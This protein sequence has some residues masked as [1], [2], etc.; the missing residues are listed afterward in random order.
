MAARQQHARD[1]TPRRQPQTLIIAAFSCAP[2]GFSANPVLS[3]N[4]IEPSRGAVTRRKTPCQC[5]AMRTRRRYRVRGGKS[6]GP[7]TVANLERSRRAR[8]K[9]GACSRD[10]RDLIASNPHAGARCG[11][12]HLAEEENLGCRGKPQGMLAVTTHHLACRLPRAPSASADCQPIDT[13]DCISDIRNR[14][15]V[16]H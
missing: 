9:H 4:S 7:R 5:P 16:E 12:C 10:V 1:R 14:F 6:T 11:S 2:S 13:R 8:W 3:R 15:R